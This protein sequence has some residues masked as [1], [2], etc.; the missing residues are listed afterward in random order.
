MATKLA[1]IPCVVTSITTLL[2]SLVKG[3][4]KVCVSSEP[5]AS[6]LTSL[7]SKPVKSLSIPTLSGAA[8][9]DIVV[10]C[11]NFIRQNYFR[12]NGVLIQN[13]QNIICFCVLLIPCVMATKFTIALK[14]VYHG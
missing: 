8:Q 1:L 3:I 2:V 5:V 14:A 12:Q 7:H 11:L 13:E 4:F 6:V 9:N 10:S